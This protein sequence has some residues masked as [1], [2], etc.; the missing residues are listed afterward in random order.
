M[1]ESWCLRLATLDFNLVTSQRAVINKA[2]VVVQSETSV[3]FV[4]VSA[5]TVDRLLA[6]EVAI[7]VNRQACLADDQYW[8]FEIQHRRR[9]WLVNPA[10]IGVRGGNKP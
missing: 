3:M 6:V 2:W 7:I 10:I 4:A 1:V 8:R 9:T 5:A